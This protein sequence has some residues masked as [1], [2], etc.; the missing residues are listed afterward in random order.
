MLYHDKDVRGH[1]PGERMSEMGFKDA[2]GWWQTLH[3]DHTV[4]QVRWSQHTYCWC[5]A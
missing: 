1:R 3:A 4:M 5:P 2:Q